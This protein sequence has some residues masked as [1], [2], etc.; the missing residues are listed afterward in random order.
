M[1]M[2]HRW[3]VIFAISVAIICVEGFFALGKLS[4]RFKIHRFFV[5]TAIIIGVLITSGYLKYIVE[6]SMWPPGVNWG[7]ME[8]L[9]GYLSYVQP[10]PYNTKVF[11][12]CSDEFKVLAFDKL[13]EPWD[14]TYHEFKLTAFNNSAQQTHSWLKSRGY[15]YLT[16]DSYCLRKYDINATNDKLAEIGNSTYFS[17]VNG[18]KGFFLF[19][20]L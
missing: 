15:E 7:S 3:W 19:K 4:E 17:F 9:Q 5:Y 11:P 13:A 12:V 1:L 10:L 16:L 18:N 20:V 2:P 6:T 14:P 8:E